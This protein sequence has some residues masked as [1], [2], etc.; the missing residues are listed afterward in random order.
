MLQV[1]VNA[2]NLK[3]HVQKKEQGHL[4]NFLPF[5]QNALKTTILY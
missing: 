1:T 2:A 3:K 4:D 5:S